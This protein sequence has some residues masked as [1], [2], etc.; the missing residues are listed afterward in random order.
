MSCLG[1]DIRAAMVGAVAES[2]LPIVGEQISCCSVSQR[3]RL[4]Q[5][6]Q[7]QCSFIV[8]RKTAKLSAS[9]SNL[10]SSG[11]MALLYNL[12][13]A[14]SEKS[15]TQVD[16]PGPSE[17]VVDITVVNLGTTRGVGGS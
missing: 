3:D 12:S 7:L 6:K 9:P 2:N 17:K 5:L 13:A 10:S 16:H 4:D 15:R 11:E 14:A 8:A 1:G